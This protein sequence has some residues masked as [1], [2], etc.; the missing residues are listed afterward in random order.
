MMHFCLFIKTCA[1]FLRLRA[2]A[3]DPTFDTVALPALMVYKNGQLIGNFVRV[4][5]EFEPFTEDAVNSFLSLFCGLSAGM[6]NSNSPI[7]RSEFSDDE[8]L[9]D[10]C[11]DF[12]NH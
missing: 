5:E 6:R 7:Y 8:E 3:V 12:H 10:F 2:F 4:W 11:S 9:K 1:K